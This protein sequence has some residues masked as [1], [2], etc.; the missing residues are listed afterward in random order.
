[1]EIHHASV[2][3]FILLPFVNH[4]WLLAA[5]TGTQV[6]ELVRIGSQSSQI[7]ITA[8]SEKDCVCTHVRLEEPTESQPHLDGAS[9][10]DVSCHPVSCPSTC[11][12]TGKQRRLTGLQITKD[13]AISSLTRQMCLAS[14]RA[15][16]LPAVLV[17][18]SFASCVVQGIHSNENRLTD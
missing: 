18:A 8:S 15:S 9:A 11:T 17:L 14:S 3:L 13:F 12:G 1:M 5:C 7:A 6:A 16:G 4:C 10:S 2:E